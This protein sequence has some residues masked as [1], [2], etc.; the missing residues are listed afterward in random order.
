MIFYTINLSTIVSRETIQFIQIEFNNLY[1][2]H[3]FSFINVS[4]ETILI[5]TAINCSF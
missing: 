3:F 5:K 1:C 2:N 4:R